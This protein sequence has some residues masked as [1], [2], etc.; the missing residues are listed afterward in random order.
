MNTARRPIIA[1]IG[2][3]QSDATLLVEAERAGALI[4]ASGA[5][6][7]TGGLGGIME[8][9]SKG[10][11][12]AGGLTIGIL[13]GDNKADANPYVDMA[14]PTGFGIGRNIVLVRTADALLAMGGQYG[15][16][17]EIAYALQM[18]KPVVGIGTW[19]IEGV[20]SVKDASEAV[21]LITETM[22]D[23]G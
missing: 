18:G 16:L 14:I 15:T 5:V 7:A 20:R 22:G 23:A 2:G 8:A 19:E 12:D 1:V 3:R 11:R 6:L 4:A 21:S 10:A 17:S 13:P 9:A